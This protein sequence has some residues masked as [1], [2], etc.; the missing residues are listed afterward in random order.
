M[1]LLDGNV[2]A[3][4][5]VLAVILTIGIAWLIVREKRV[6]KRITLIGLIILFCLIGII[7]KDGIGDIFFLPPMTLEFG[8][9]VTLLVFTLLRFPTPFAPTTVLFASIA[10]LALLPVH[11]FAANLMMVGLGLLFFIP[12]IIQTKQTTYAQ[13]FQ[14]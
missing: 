10:Y 2:A 12:F 11:A 3:V 7:G 9:M 5:E 13:F 8:L 6:S 1:V 14:K 4:V